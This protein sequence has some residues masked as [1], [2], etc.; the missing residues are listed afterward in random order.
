MKY[1]IRCTNP[2]HTPTD[3]R[4]WQ[5]VYYRSDF[6]DVASLLEGHHCYDYVRQ[7]EK[8]YY[9]HHRPCMYPIDGIYLDQLQYFEIKIDKKSLSVV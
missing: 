2:C 8:R 1:T 3:G 7:D 9:S 4:V 6:Q 5:D